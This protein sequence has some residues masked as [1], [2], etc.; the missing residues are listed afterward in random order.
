MMRIEV[1]PADGDTRMTTV[2]MTGST[3]GLL[4]DLVCASTAV[5]LKLMQDGVLMPDA[6]SV[7]EQIRD[8]TREQLR[9]DLDKFVRPGMGST[10]KREGMLQ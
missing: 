4:I 8:M 3:E 6:D 10:D 1:S 7:T 2:E 5:L 9:R